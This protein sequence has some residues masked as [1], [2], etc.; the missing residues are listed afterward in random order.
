M[1]EQIN[2]QVIDLWKNTKEYNQGW[3]ACNEGKLIFVNPYPILDENSN[4]WNAGWKD[5]QRAWNNN[6]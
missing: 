2:I 5:C 1:T 3:N 6:F 4:R